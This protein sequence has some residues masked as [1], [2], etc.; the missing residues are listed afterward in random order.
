M[1]MD[2]ITL[3]TSFSKLG[4]LTN[5]ISFVG[6]KVFAM[7]N[8]LI[9][10]NPSTAM[11]GTAA[12]GLSKRKGRRVECPISNN[13]GLLPRRCSY[14]SLLKGPKCENVNSKKL[15]YRLSSEGFKPQLSLNKN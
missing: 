2:V 14:V 1:F 8:F 11:T 10:S 9:A 7:L 15:L 12:V 5:T 4:P 3:P 6:R 13:M